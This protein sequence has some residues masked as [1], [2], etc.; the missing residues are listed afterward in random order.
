MTWGKWLQSSYNKGGF[1]YE[2]YNPIDRVIGPNGNG[3]Y[4]FASTSATP[5]RTEW[6]ISANEAYSFS[7]GSG[8]V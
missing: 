1:S 8:G 5:E 4:V 2:T 7:T 3:H 6:T